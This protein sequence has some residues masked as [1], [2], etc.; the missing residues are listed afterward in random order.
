MNKIL[1]LLSVGILA[2]GM[3]LGFA[4]TPALCLAA[5]SDGTAAA[6]D[7]NGSVKKTVKKKKKKSSSKASAVKAEEEDAEESDGKKTAIKTKKTKKVKK[8][9]ATEADDAEKEADAA[10][11]DD[12]EGVK[13]AKAENDEEKAEET[14]DDGPIDASPISE[15][16]TEAGE[17]RKITVRGVEYAFCWCPAGSFEMGAPEDELGYSE[18]E[19]LH[20]VKLSK[21]F[22]MLQTEVTQEMFESVMDRNPSYF[23]AKSFGKDKGFVSGREETAKFPVDRVSYADAVNFCEKFSDLVGVK[24]ALPTEAQWEYACRAGTTYPFYTDKT[25]TP[26]QANFKKG[27]S[28][29][30]STDEVGKHGKNPWNLCDMMGNVNE[31]CRDYYAP[32]YY[33]NSPAADPQGPDS[34]ENDERVL[35]GGSFANLEYYLRSAAR[36]FLVEGAKGNRFDGFR[37]MTAPGGEAAPEAAADSDDEE[38]EDAD[39]G[40]ADSDDEEKEDADEET[41]DSDDEEKEDADEE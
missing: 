21:G 19:K 17:V 11:A 25:P 18:T 16:G 10:E 13:E 6:A 1:G 41:A 20:S 15:E 38:K 33:E 2:L 23:S 31:W 34:A 28:V 12:S 24:F 7:E 3:L 36:N 14:A 8:S 39:E 5:E 35:R 4:L 27:E 29:P 40:T 9:S 32:D 22:W 26:Q 30:E 37:F